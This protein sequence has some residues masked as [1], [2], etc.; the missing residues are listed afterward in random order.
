L[1]NGVNRLAVQRVVL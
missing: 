1:A